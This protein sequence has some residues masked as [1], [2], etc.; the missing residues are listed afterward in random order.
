LRKRTHDVI[1]NK[2][3]SKKRTQRK[4][5]TAALPELERLVAGRRANKKFSNEPKWLVATSPIWYGD[6]LDVSGS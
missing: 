3:I 6:G 5:V 4:S 1:E 2:A